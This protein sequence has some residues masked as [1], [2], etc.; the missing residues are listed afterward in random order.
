MRREV[1][2]GSTEEAIMRP[3]QWTEPEMV[4]FVREMAA[5]RERCDTW[6]WEAGYIEHHRDLRVEYEPIEPTSPPPKGCVGFACYGPCCWPPRG[7]DE[8]NQVLCHSC[9]QRKRGHRDDRNCEHEWRCQRC[10]VAQ[11]A[12]QA[13]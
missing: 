6:Q 3:R 2:T 1:Q 4:N 7:Y 5:K 8:L 10:G 11:K 12:R 9:M 13:S